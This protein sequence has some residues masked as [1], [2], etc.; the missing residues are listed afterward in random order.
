MMCN[1][2]FIGSMLECAC[3]GTSYVQTGV[4]LKL[5]TMYAAE[6]GSARGALWNIPLSQS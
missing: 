4:K 6:A 1:S 3:V 5:V 2:L